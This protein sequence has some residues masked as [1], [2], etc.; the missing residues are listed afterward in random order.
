MNVTLPR[1]TASCDVLAERVC[2]ADL[3]EFKLCSRSERKIN[4]VQSLKV[5]LM[6]SCY[7]SESY[8]LERDRQNIMIASNDLLNVP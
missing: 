6:L 7:C 8:G 1:F 5:F 4:D 2:A 3:A